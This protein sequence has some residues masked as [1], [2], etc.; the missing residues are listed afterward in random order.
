MIR[1]YNSIKPHGEDMRMILQVHD[2]LI[3]EVKESLADEAA[4]I[5][6]SEMESAHELSV[7]LLVETSI[8][9]AWDEVH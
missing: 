6:K 8:G 1:V 3:L 9:G 7:P 4:N 5:L 2:E